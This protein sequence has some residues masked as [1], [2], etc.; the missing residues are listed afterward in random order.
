MKMSVIK[1][2]LTLT[3][4]LPMA[5]G[6]C[7]P[8]D[9]ADEFRSGVPRHEDVSLAFPGNASTSQALSG[10]EGSVSAPLLGEKSEFYEV[11]RAIT[12]TVNVATASVLG[13][14]KLITAFPP[15]S[16]G[17]DV[18][19]WGPHTEPLSPNT[20]RLTVH[21]LA[22]GQFQYQFEAKDKTKD[23][24]AYVIVL[25]G[26]HNV[27]NPMVHRR[28]AHLPDYG[29]GDFI[30]D[31]DAAQTLPEHDDNVGT[32]AFTY[33]RLSP[34]A[35]IMIDVDFHNVRDDETQMLVDATYEY[36]AT[37]GAG[38]DFQFTITKN[39]V[40]TTTAPET[41]SIR[42]RWQE[43]GAGR[44][45]ARFN[46]G[47][48]AMGATANECWDSVFKSVYMTNSYGDAAKMWGAETACVFPTAEYDSL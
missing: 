21:R 25:S 33:S 48:L 22:L 6:A 15:T 41:L 34:T 38:G 20:W 12:V 5:L 44:S 29:H 19:V 1:T 17:M 42:S 31:W 4:A 45:D 30:I 39:A 36:T 43:S 7:K 2:G 37:P 8:L 18:A 35:D 27:A 40:V 10:G 3:L 16:I 23:D 28:R 46:G 26:H 24:S 47:D 32:A 9:D 11:T 13:L 14:V